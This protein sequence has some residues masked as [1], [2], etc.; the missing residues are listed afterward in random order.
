MEID[1]IRSRKLFDEWEKKLDK[2][3][4]QQWKL[5]TIR[6]SATYMQIIPIDKSSF[7]GF[8]YTS[9]WFVFFIAF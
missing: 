8:I 1:I 3:Y 6:Y 7:A 9:L 5:N 4:A 2:I